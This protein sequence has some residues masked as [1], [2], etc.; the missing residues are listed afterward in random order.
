MFKRYS[1]EY[2]LEFSQVNLCNMWLST[3]KIEYYITKIKPGCWVHYNER[4]PINHIQSYLV[5]NMSLNSHRVLCTWQHKLNIEVVSW[6]QNIWSMK[7]CEIWRWVSLPFYMLNYHEIRERFDDILRGHDNM[8][9]T[10]KAPPRRLHAYVRTLLS[11][12]DSL[13]QG[14]NIKETLQ[15]II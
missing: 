8:V 6:H 1:V 10:L 13:L 11:C 7:T 2:L 9:D 15:F 14:M 4:T 5:A 12:R 3:S